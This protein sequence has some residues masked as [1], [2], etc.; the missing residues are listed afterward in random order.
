[1]LADSVEAA[2]R[3]ASTNGRLNDESNGEGQRVTNKLKEVV[4][5]VIKSRLEEGQLDNCDLTLRQIEQVRATFL[6][7]LEGIY[8]PRIEYPELA[9]AGTSITPAASA[10]PSVREPAEAAH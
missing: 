2:V 8:H 3:A 7:I 1:M 5:N 4:D 10:A 9:P 6:T